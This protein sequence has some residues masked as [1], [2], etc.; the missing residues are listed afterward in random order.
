[1]CAWSE[2]QRRRTPPGDNRWAPPSPIKWANDQHARFAGLLGPREHAENVITIRDM[3][4][5]DQSQV[6]LPEAAAY[7]HTR[8]RGT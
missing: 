6:P 7:L 5:G 4:T 8:I 2:D 1:M 3:H